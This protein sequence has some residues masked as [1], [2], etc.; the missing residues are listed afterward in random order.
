[1]A[2]DMHDS[3]SSDMLANPM[4]VAKF[5]EHIER[6]TKRRDFL[7][8]RINESYQELSF[9]K[10]EAS[11]LDFVLD[12]IQSNREQALMHLDQYLKNK[13]EKGI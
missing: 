8:R 1:M 13:A 7:I 3:L 4:P 11:S 12:F 6:L 10:A 9:D 2:V 5:N